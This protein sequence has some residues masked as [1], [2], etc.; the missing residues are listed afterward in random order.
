MATT[1]SHRPR[2]RALL[3]GLI[4]AAA[5]AALAFTTGAANAAPTIGYTYNHELRWWVHQSLEAASY[6]DYGHKTIP[7]PVE[8]RCYTANRA[9]DQAAYEPGDTLATLATTEAFYAGG[10]TVNMR[11][12]T[13]SQAERFVHGI[14]T[15]TTAEAFETL[16]HEGLH[17]Q[18]IRSEWLTEE[19]AIASSYSAGKLVRYE[20]T[21]ELGGTPSWD[22]PTVTAS[23][24]ET[25]A[26]ALDANRYRPA[27]YRVTL[28]G[29]NAAQS[30]GWAWAASHRL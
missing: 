3:A 4:L 27:S 7:Q 17:R 28:K 8:V 13:C 18:G 2:R 12:L 16:L 25:R 5:A 11:P 21:I 9:F 29:V 15:P 6:G 19:F 30:V 24:L 23:G 14:I 20:R 22:G 26:Y 1:S 10:N